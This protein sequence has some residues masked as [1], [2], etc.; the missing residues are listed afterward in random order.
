[1]GNASF[2]FEGLGYFGLFGT[3]FPCGRQWTPP[4]QSDPL[5]T[6]Q[7]PLLE[8]PR[9]PCRPPNGVFRRMMKI[10]C[11]KYEKLKVKS[12]KIEKH[13]KETE[14]LPFPPI[15]EKKSYPNFIRRH[16]LHF[17][18]S[19]LPLAQEKCG[20]MALWMHSPKFLGMACMFVLRPQL[21]FERGKNTPANCTLSGGHQFPLF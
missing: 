17:S 6:T 14:V 10:D 1:M 15:P 8:S 16:L 3:D 13:K 7:T 9:Q 5:G 21:L 19:I 4:L 18:S 12:R 11:E 20:S 2:R